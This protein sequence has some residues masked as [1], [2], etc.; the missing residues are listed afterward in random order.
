MTNQH[1]S[2]DR[3]S[4]RAIALTAEARRQAQY[5]TLVLASLPAAAILCAAAMVLARLLAA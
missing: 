4:A 3:R 1:Y 5:Q 2:E